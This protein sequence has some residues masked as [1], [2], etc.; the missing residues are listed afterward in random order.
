M[1][2]R[3]HRVPVK[4][5]QPGMAPRPIVARLLHFRDRDTILQK[6]QTLEQI[7]VNSK[8]M[9]FPDFTAA[10]QQQRASFLTVKRKLREMGVK[11]ALMFPA[12]L[13]IIQGSVAR[14]FLDQQEAWQWLEGEFPTEAGPWEAAGSRKKARK[15]TQRG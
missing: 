6:A 8:V 7:T 13:K 3:A 5:P 15:G 10:V 12:K 9:L 2:E 11:Y 1:L 14:F 4:A